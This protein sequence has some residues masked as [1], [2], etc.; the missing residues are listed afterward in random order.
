MTDEAKLVE[1]LLVAK[2]YVPAKAEWFEA[3]EE[4]SGGEIKPEHYRAMLLCEDEPGSSSILAQMMLDQTALSLAET[5][6]TAASAAATITRLIAER[7]GAYERA[8]QVAEKFSR[9]M[10]SPNHTDTGKMIA[11]AIRSLTGDSNHG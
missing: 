4:V 5:I 10:H 2:G 1:R 11:T 8:A 9:T 3:I 6:D 7:D